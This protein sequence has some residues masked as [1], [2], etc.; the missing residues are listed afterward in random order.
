MQD[1][2][3]WLA[4][5]MFTRHSHKNKH[6]GIICKGKGET[7]KGEYKRDN[8]N[9][10]VFVYNKTFGTIYLL[11]TAYLQLWKKK[12]HEVIN[13]NINC[14]WFLST[15]QSNKDHLHRLDIGI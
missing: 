13:F 4:C 6:V 9:L 7:I 12:H 14:S 11:F 1:Y 10:A 15:L 5:G 3:P 2:T 8:L